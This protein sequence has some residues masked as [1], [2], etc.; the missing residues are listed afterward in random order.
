MS[1]TPPSLEPAIS[2]NEARPSLASRLLNIFAAPGDV[3]DSIKSTA[4]EHSNWVVPAL[5]LMVAGWIGGA[6]ILSQ[7][8]VKQQIREASDKAI[9]KQIAKQHMSEAQAEQVR[10]TA[11]KFSTIGPIIGAA[12]TPI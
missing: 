1:E 6:L 4:V 9:E 8:S 2:A 5:I 7:E 10:Q 11:E 3:F 12:F